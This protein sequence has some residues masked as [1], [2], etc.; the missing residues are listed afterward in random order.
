MVQIL[1]DKHKEAVFI[2]VYEGLLD[3]F[4]LM[5]PLH[6]YCINSFKSRLIAVKPQ[7]DLL[8]CIYRGKDKNFKINQGG[9]TVRLY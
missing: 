5:D 9:N 7:I 6:Y 4:L 8:D 2:T 1:R 3:Y